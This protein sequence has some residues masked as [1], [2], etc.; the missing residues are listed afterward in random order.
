MSKITE[1]SGRDSSK[2]TEM[3]R[4]GKE[5]TKE[6]REVETKR[7]TT[8]I[9][10]GNSET[11][12][13]VVKVARQ[14]VFVDLGRRERSS[15]TKARLRNGQLLETEARGRESKGRMIQM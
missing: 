10:T 9:W 1:L 3:I 2:E 5:M 6:A 7:K 15:K 12:G 8:E 4:T 14:K 13:L 11:T